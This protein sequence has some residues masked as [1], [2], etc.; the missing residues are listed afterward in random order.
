V[1]YSSHKSEALSAT[2]YANYECDN[3]NVVNLDLKTLWDGELRQ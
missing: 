2:G 1:P 3:K